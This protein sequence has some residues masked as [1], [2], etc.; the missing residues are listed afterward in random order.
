LKYKKITIVFNYQGNFDYPNRFN[1]DE[2]F[3]FWNNYPNSSSSQNIISLPQYIDQKSDS[4]RK[5]VLQNIEFF[6]SSHFLNKNIYNFL[7]PKRGLSFWHLTPLGE[8]ANYKK[9]KALNEISKLLAIKEIISKF[10]FSSIE[11]IGGN[12]ILTRFICDIATKNQITFTK[13]R[14]K[15]FK[16]LS[17]KKY[18]NL[19]KD[20]IGSFLWLIKFLFQFYRPKSKFRSSKEF[21]KKLKKNILFISYHDFSL[22]KESKNPYWGNLINKVQDMNYG[23]NF[24]H[25]YDVSN[26]HKNYSDSLNDIKNYK[27]TYR[28]EN[29]YSLYQFLTIGIWSI[30]FRDNL[31][32]WLK[33][34][35]LGLFTKSKCEDVVQLIFLKELKKSIRSPLAAKNL[36]EY[37]IIKNALNSIKN[38][39]TCIYLRENLS[40]EQSLVYHIKQSF[41]VKAI[42]YCH[43]IIRFWDLR[44][45][46][47]EKRYSYYEN[48][49]PDEIFVNGLSCRD[50]LLK[51]NFQLNKIKIVEALRFQNLHSHIK[52]NLYANLETERKNNILILADYSDKETSQILKVV[53]NLINPKGFNFDVILK[54]HPNSNSSFIDKF[55]FIKNEY[56]NEDIFSLLEK[57][58]Y[59]ISS[60]TT[61]A[62]IIPFVNKIP[63]FIF[64]PNT[65][66]MSPLIKFDSIF[67]SN[68]IELKE[69]ISQNGSEKDYSQFLKEIFFTDSNLNS[70]NEALN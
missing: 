19:I 26:N 16:N 45:Y 12:K 14:T 50:Q 43:T 27:I 2:I 11:L 9:V 1:V 6:R 46:L 63:T 35:L 4:I 22:K 10:E 60:N 40:W 69:K 58:K 13:T 36:I 68:A 59:V 54:H 25:I 66:N 31:I 3:L 8:Q 23:I 29:H 15:I 30:A 47:P 34:H 57:T 51:N 39:D 70:W 18:L 7:K 61:T 42:G 21:S 44:Y 52:E 38:I 53:E 56:F 41:S 49:I 32:I 55:S 33:S 62:S 67:F 48:T 17:F 37:R 65:F 24:L 64:R 28:H 20:Y 5:K